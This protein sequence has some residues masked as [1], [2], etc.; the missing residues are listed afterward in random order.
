MEADEREPRCDVKGR[1]ELALGVTSPD[2]AGEGARG[3]LG[4]LGAGEG[5]EVEGEGFEITAGVTKV[6]GEDSGV[7]GESGAGCGGE[8]KTE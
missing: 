3:A 6:V 1:C 7:S 4:A 8:R 5:P 2:G